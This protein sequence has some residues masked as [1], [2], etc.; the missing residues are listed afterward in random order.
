MPAGTVVGS[1]SSVMIRLEAMHD[2]AW[3]EG[4]AAAP[5]TAA[6]N[7]FDTGMFL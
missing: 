1:A 2:A 7:A 3:T 6:S 4:A 5:S